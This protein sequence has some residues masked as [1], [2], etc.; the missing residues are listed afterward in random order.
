MGEG[1]SGFG[2]G[3]R[4]RRSGFGVRGRLV[5]VDA[6][7]LGWVRRMDIMGWISR[8]LVREV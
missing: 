3:G 4:L 5:R 7:L 8:G 1:R 6:A 2:V